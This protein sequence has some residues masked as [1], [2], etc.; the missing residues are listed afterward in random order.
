[1]LLLFPVHRFYFSRG[2][3]SKDPPSIDHPGLE[4]Q[5]SGA[6]RARVAEDNLTRQAVSRWVPPLVWLRRQHRMSQ[7]C[8]SKLISAMKAID[9][10][11]RIDSILYIGPATRKPSL[12]I[13]YDQGFVSKLPKARPRLL[14]SGFDLQRGI[15]SSASRLQRWVSSRRPSFTAD[16]PRFPPKMRLSGF[17]QDSL[18]IH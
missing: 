5:T 10:D 6:F 16:R 17:P 13:S 15:F 1:M 2:H 12:P 8:M 7:K 3:G 18:R 4:S 14:D 11:N 9:V